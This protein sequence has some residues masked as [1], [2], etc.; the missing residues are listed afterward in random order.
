MEND[1]TNKIIIT[2]ENE[3]EYWE[4]FQKTSSP[5]IKEALITK[6]K[7]LLEDAIDKKL[8]SNIGKGRFKRLDYEDFLCFGY[9]GLL[10]AIDKY[11]P[12]KDAEFQTFASR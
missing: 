8:K 2:D 11:Q 12:D 9:S 10:E 4:E 5:Q 1:N 3:K 6:Y 7:N